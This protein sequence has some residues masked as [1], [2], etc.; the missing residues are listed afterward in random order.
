VLQLDG[1][2]LLM[3][4]GLEVCTAMHLAENMVQLPEHILKKI[5]PPKWFVEKYPEDKW[6]WDVGQYPKF[7][8]LLEPCH[9]NKILKTIKVGNAVLRLVKLRDLID[10]YVEYLQ[11]NPDIFYS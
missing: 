4:I 2:I 6:E 9:Q 11:K 7:A 3:G 8:K 1:Y 10:L 5:T